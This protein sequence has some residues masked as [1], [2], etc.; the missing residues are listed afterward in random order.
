MMTR[1]AIL[2]TRKILLRNRELR[3]TKAIHAGIDSNIVYE[4]Y[5]AISKAKAERMGKQKERAGKRKGREKH[6][7][8]QHTRYPIIQEINGNSAMR[9]YH[10]RMAI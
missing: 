3:R 2:S 7:V 10:T 6:R 4:V 9:R 8:G 1:P 5:S